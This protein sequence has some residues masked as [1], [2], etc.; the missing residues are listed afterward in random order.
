MI[1]IELASSLAAK[2]GRNS[3]VSRSELQPG[4]L[5]LP[6]EHRSSSPASLGSKFS[7]ARHSNNHSLAASPGGCG[8]EGTNGS[9]FLSVSSM[10]F[11]DQLPR[12]L[13]GVRCG[14]GI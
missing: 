9:G 13:P 10:L 5:L 1:R 6:T 8:T 4:A 14:V 2:K 3:G 12:F 11:D 7:P